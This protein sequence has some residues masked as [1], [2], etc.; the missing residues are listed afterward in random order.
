MAGGIRR[1]QIDLA[2]NTA[3]ADKEGE[4]FTQRQN[5]R[6]NRLLTDEEVAEKAKMGLGRRPTLRE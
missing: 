5:K 1:L 3:A 4:A 6:I 2:M